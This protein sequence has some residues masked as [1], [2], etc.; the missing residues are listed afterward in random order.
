MKCC[1]HSL[2]V[3]R[4]WLTIKLPR[5]VVRS[6]TNAY[7][8]GETLRQF[9]WPT[10][11]VNFNM[12]ISFIRLLREGNLSRLLYRLSTKQTLAH[13]AQSNIYSKPN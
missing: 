6:H 11:Q 9:N 8:K 13:V 5:D 12:P 1:C 3:L 7:K 2:L 10:N 4:V